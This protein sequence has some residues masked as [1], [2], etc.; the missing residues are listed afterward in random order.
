ML[1][2]A[3]TLLLALLLLA[4]SP[5]AVQPAREVFTNT[6]YVQLKGPHGPEKAHEIAKRSGFENLGSVSQTPPLWPRGGTQS[7][8]IPGHMSPPLGAARIHSRLRRRRSTA[9]VSGSGRGGEAVLMWAGRY[10]HS[11]S[12]PVCNS[13]T[14]IRHS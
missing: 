8:S 6:F 7:A 5:T 13:M 4:G 10:N 14:E 2:P 1:Q 11:H 12:L 3:A 9:V